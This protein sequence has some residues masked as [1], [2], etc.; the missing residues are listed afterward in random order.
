MNV[1]L[2]TPTAST[3]HAINTRAFP[4]TNRTLL[5]RASPRAPQ[6]KTAKNKMWMKNMKLNIIIGA[7]PRSQKR[8]PK[9]RRLQHR[10][11]KAV[12]QRGQGAWLHSK[13]KAAVQRGQ[14][15]GS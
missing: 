15:G 7:G 5:T 8:R 14:G 12:V 4:R 9:E 11:D 1:Y 6:A 13:D 10:E 2:G 3:A